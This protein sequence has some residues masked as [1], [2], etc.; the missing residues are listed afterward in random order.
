MQSIVR[1]WFVLESS[2]PSTQMDFPAIAVNP[3]WQIGRKGPP[4]SLP[5]LT[6]TI[7]GGVV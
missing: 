6:I 1:F 7:G 2:I 5:Q 4:P 3:F